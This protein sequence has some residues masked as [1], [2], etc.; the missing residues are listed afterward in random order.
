VWTVNSARCEQGRC[1]Y[2]LTLRRVRASVVAWKSNEYYIF[3]V[4]V[5]GLSYPACNVHVPSY[6][7]ICGLCGRTMFS[8]VTS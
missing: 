7:V 5:W 2:N 6:I 4:C 3:W 8:R 1:T